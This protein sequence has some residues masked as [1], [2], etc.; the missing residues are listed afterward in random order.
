MTGEIDLKQIERKA[1]RSTYQDGLWDIYWGLIVI[2]MAVFIARPEEGYSARNIL[3][4]LAS[5]LFSYS[6][7][8]FGK[9][10]ITLPRMG[11]VVFGSARKMKKKTLAVILGVVI[12]FQLAIV[13]ISV[14]GWLNQ[15]W[16]MKVSIFLQLGGTER[17][18]VAAIGALFL[19]PAMILIAYFNDF[20]RGYYIAILM[21]LAVFLMI[22]LNQPVYPLILGLAILLP[23]LILFFRFLQKYPLHNEEA[24]NG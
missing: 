7:F 10:Y 18:M 19:G 16:M 22:L 6:L 11:Q 15:V 20:P 21:T 3:L 4:M 2:C 17:L 1:F 13:L 12:L 24:D 23:G 9:K 8:W 14:T 5:F